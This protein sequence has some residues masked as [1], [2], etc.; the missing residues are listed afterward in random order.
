MRVRKLLTFS[1]R[2]LPCI[3]RL[4]LKLATLLHQDLDLSF[5]SLQLLTAGIRK[6]YAFLEELQRLLQ[7]K[8]AFLEL[9]DNFL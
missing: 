1:R 2:L 8:I 6:A 3:E 9:F 7:G 5:G 4:C